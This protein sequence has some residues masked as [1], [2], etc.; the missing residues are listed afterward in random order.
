MDISLAIN[1][2][3]VSCY[4]LC[5]WRLPYD[6]HHVS[7]SCVSCLTDVVEHVLQSSVT[8]DFVRLTIVKRHLKTVAYSSAKCG[9][10]LHAFGLLYV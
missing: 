7:D 5:R 9:T 8:V 10:S 4:K 2:I 1:F 6:G 3:S